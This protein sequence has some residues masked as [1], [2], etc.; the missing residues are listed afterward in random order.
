MWEEQGKRYLNSI[1]KLSKHFKQSNILTIGGNFIRSLNL[2][3]I[4]WFLFFYVPLHRDNFFIV[5]S[6]SSTLTTTTDFNSITQQMADWLIRKAGYHQKVQVVEYLL[7]HPLLHFNVNKSPS[8]KVIGMNK[9]FSPLI[10]DRDV[11]RD[12]ARDVELLRLLL[13]HGLN[14]NGYNMQ[15]R[16]HLWLCLVT[17]RFDLAMILL[18]HGASPGNYYDPGNHGFLLEED[19]LVDTAN[20]RRLLEEGIKQ[21]R[22][23]R[24]ERKKWA[25]LVIPS[26][27]NFTFGGAVTVENLVEFL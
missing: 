19:M 17:C 3:G 6:T 11:A 24:W 26:D 20:N 8:F 7:N 4:E 27:S 16:S 10:N 9:C 21:L 1:V 25:F 14:P 22:D 13:R 18:A 15:G 5:L 12:L 23:A 2:A